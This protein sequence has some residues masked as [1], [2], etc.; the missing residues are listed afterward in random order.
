MMTERKLSE[1]RGSITPRQREY[2]SALYREA[3]KNLFT[4]RSRELIG[5][6]MAH[7]DTS[8]A[9]SA[10]SYIGILKAAKERGWTP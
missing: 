1:R 9:A 4:L 3:V 2:L 10:S 7:L 8:S 5:L 6:D